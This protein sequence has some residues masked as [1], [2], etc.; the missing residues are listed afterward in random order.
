MIYRRMMACVYWG[1]L[2]WNV[3]VL[4][5]FFYVLAYMSRSIQS[6]RQAR[7]IHQ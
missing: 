2:A 3:F 7:G 1:G 5:M 4:A 6:E